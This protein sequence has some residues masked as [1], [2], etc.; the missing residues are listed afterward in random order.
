MIKKNCLSS[1]MNH[2][3]DNTCP[4]FLNLEICINK[5]GQRICPLSGK[6]FQ[7][8]LNHGRY[9]IDESPHEHISSTTRNKRRIKLEDKDKRKKRIKESNSKKTHKINRIILDDIETN[10]SDNFLL[11]ETRKYLELIFSSSLRQSLNEKYSLSL[12]IVDK[13]DS[14]IQEYAKK[15]QQLWI[16][17]CQ[18]KFWLDSKTARR[19]KIEAFLTGFLYTIQY[20]VH[21]PSLFEHNVDTFLQRY[22]P[23]VGN[24]EYFEIKKRNIRIGKNFIFSC[25]RSFN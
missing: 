2:V 20:G 22:L 13:N 14:I 10:D 12:P 18:S 3:C 17:L 23:P 9:T 6:C 5:E 16:I 11:S 1:I 21:F 7:S 4:Y 24:L 19:I 15:C 25:L 8:Y